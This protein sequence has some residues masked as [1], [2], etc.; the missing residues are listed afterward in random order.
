M[1]SLISFWWVSFAK[2]EYLHGPQLSKK[3]PTDPWNIPQIWKKY[4]KIQCERIP[5]INRWFRVQGM[6]QGYVGIFLET[7]Y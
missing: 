5:F 3:I 6:F 2:W 7:S 1:K 4:E